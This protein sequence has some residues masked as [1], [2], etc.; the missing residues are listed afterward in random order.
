MKINEFMI[1]DVISVHEETKIKQLL[2]I[3]VNNKI[4]GFP[5][6]DETDRLKGMISD[7]DIIRHL[8]PKG[9]TIYDMFSLVIVNEHED[10]Q[11]KITSCVDHQ[12]KDIMKKN[13]Y[14]VH[15]DDDVEKAISIFSNHHF[16]KIPVVNEDKQ[17]MGVVSRGDIIRFISTKIIAESTD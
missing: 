4:G 6:V 10:F 1:T 17:V 11:N 7:G 16:K 2:Q 14:A 3:L 5:V 13:I 9:R 12:A 8:Q 15:P